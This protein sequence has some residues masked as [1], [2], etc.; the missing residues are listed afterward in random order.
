MLDDECKLLIQVSHTNYI[1]LNKSSNKINPKIFGSYNKKIR[2][3]LIMIFVG[4]G[5]DILCDNSAS[6]FSAIMTH[7]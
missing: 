5:K 3:F 7:V 2:G 1:A 4:N 6:H